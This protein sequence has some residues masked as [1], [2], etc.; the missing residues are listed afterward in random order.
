MTDTIFALSSGRGRAGVAVLR[1]SGPRAGAALLAI[2]GG[3]LPEPRFAAFRR[4]RHP[5][6]D[7]TLDRALALWFPGPRS[8]TG[9]DMAEFHLHGGPAVVAGVADVLAG[10]EGLRPAEPGEFTRRAFLNGKLD[11][12]AVEGLADLVAAE[13]AAQRR[14]A[15]RQMDGALL[16]LYE[17]W[18]ARL[19]KAM[20]L[21]EVGIDFSEEEVPA[22]VAEGGRRVAADLA[23]EIRRHLDD[24]HRGQR[25][26]SGVQVAIV[27]PPN[28]GKST[29]LN[30]LAERDA[31]IVSPI[32]GTTRDV[33]DIDL[34]LDGFPVRIAD[35]AGLRDTTD[36][37][38]AEGVRRARGRADQADLVVL[39]LDATTWPGAE[40][41]GIRTLPAEVIVLLNKNDLR[42]VPGPLA[43]QGRPV[44]PVSLVTGDGFAAARAAIA[45]RVRALSDTAGS[46]VLTRARHRAALGTAA[47]ALERAG[48][49]PAVELLAEDLRLAARSLGRITGR[50]EVDDVLDVVFREFCI[51][52]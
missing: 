8:E 33:I 11:L 42:P 30:R 17:D 40:P 36:P 1:L 46:P 9:E 52:K 15:I 29:L 39:V 45:D 22:D 20:A 2:A 26:R 13:T 48:A 3:T 44:L 10:L 47:D 27:G 41:A 4:L 25:L 7:E 21:V 19:V 50:V 16:R 32:A 43:F 34:D 12:T 14:Q 28:A 35:T 51:G 31:A 37:V 38:E 5:K 6:T 24:G 49:V 18:R 23:R